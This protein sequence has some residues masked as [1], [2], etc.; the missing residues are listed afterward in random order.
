MALTVI[1]VS[2][3]HKNG[4]KRLETSFDCIDKT[5]IWTHF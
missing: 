5:A 3:L 4:Q 2:K 1:N